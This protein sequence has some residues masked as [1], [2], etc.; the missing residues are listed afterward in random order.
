MKL[1]FHQVFVNLQPFQKLKICPDLHG[2]TK[3]TG[4]SPGEGCVLKEPRCTEIL[5]E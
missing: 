4:T 2:M 3:G 5:K 1:Y